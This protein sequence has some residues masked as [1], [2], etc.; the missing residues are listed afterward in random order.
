MFKGNVYCRRWTYE[1][2]K[3]KAWGIRYSVNGTVKREIVAD[4]KEGAQAELDKKREDY[5]QRLLG[6]AEG[7]TLKDL[8]PL[9][10]ERQQTKER[11]MPTIEARLKNLLAFFRDTPLEEIEDQADKYKLARRATYRKK[12][13]KGHGEDERCPRCDRRIEKGTVNREVAT[14]N[15]MLHLAKT[16]FKLLRYQPIIERLEGEAGPRERELTESEEATLLPVCGQDLRDLIE[17]G[18]M[19]GMREGELIHLTRGQ[20]DLEDRLIDFHPTKRGLK[21]LMPINERLYYLLCRRCAGLSPADV[22]FSLDSRPWQRWHIRNRLKVAIKRTGI[23]PVRFH[24][25]RHTAASRLRRAG[26]D[27][28]DIRK[29]LG[30]R[31]VKTTDGYVHYEAEQLRPV[32]ALLGTPTPSTRDAHG[33]SESTKRTQEPEPVSYH[34][35]NSLN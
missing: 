13:C 18:L 17:A 20:V 14:L 27:M 12:P 32:L 3:R 7:K 21:R 23:A 2:K 10:L 33:F 9:Y 34:S 4:T 19:T 1:G 8:A 22:V 35:G 26:A 11:N 25:L 28:D 16:K 31:N 6:V 24:D 5:Q 29:L 30:H 15:H